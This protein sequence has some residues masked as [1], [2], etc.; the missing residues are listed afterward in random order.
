MNDNSKTQPD[1]LTPVMVFP[2]LNFPIKIMGLN[3]PEFPVA[4]SELASGSSA[5]APRGRDDDGPLQ[6]RQVS[7]AQ[8]HGERAVSGT[9]RQLLPRPDLAPDGQGGAL[10][11]GVEDV[12]PGSLK[13][14]MAF[15][16]PEAW[17]VAVAPVIAA[18]SLALFETGRF[19][20]LTAFFTMTIALLMQIISNMKNDLGYTE[21]EGGNRQPQGA[22][23]CNHPGLDLHSRRPKGY[24][25]AHR[26]GT[27]QHRRAHLARRLGLRADRHLLGHRRLFVHGRSEAHCLHAVRRGDGAR[28]L[29]SHG[30]LRLLLPAD[31][32]GVGKRRPPEHLAR[33]DRGRRARRQQLEGQGARQ[34]H[35]PPERLQSCSATRPSRQSSES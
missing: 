9:A 14:W 10:M 13:A 32:H 3:Q 34:E 16:R 30:R 27:A 25:H 19:D 35:R 1:D 31:L 33:L 17:G 12:K 11:T 18:L 15:T 20:A 5:P 21:K 4:I 6:D 2:M 8:H 7:C 23:P 24:S 22:S 26:A 29:R 28:I